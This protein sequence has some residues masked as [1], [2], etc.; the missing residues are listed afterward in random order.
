MCGCVFSFDQTQLDM[1][2]RP[3]AVAEHEL[4][5]QGVSLIMLER[6]RLSR[7][8]ELA[9][10]ERAGP[11]NYNE[12]YSVVCPCRDMRRCRFRHFELLS[13]KM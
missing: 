2:G 5:A 11:K 12:W 1:K 8:H 3:A 7:T 13:A 10:A 4:E 9:A 6:L